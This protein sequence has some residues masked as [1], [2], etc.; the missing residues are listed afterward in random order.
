MNSPAGT[1]LR[2]NPHRLELARIGFEITAP[3]GTV[4]TLED[5]EA[6][7]QTLDLWNGII[8]SRF[9]AAGEEVR[10][11]T[12]CHP[13][14]D[15]LAFRFESP[16]IEA[17]RLKI[18]FRFPYGSKGFRIEPQDWDQPERHRTEIVRQS[19][20]RVDLKRVLDRDSYYVS[21]ASSPSGF[22][23]VGEHRYE[24]VPDKES[25]TF[26]FCAAFSPFEIN[27]DLP[28]FD[29]TGQAC[30]NHW[31]HFWEMGAAIDFSASTD[32]R[33]PEL[34]RR[35]V[36]SQY[37]TAVQCAGDTPPQETGLTCNSWHGKFHLEMHWWHGVHFALWGRL[38]LL[39]KSLGWYSE[40][41]SEARKIAR[42]QGYAGVR[43][44]KM[45]DPS[46][47]DSP[48][49]CGPYLIWQ[50]PHPIYYAELCYRE[51]GD[52]ATLAQYSKLVFETA[53]FMASYARWDEAGERYVLGPA[54]IPAQ[55]CY[56]PRDTM[57]PPFE[58]EYWSW[59]LATAGQWRERLGMEREPAWD[60]VLEKLSPPPMDE[61]AYQTAEGVWKNRDHP[62]LLGACGILPGRT[63]DREVMRRTL[64]MVMDEWDWQR[65][66]GWDFPMVA[67]TAARLDE[68]EL[69]IDVLMMDR[70]KNHYCP[71]GHNRQSTALPLYLPGNGGLL[72]AVA[73]MAA[74]WD[75][76]PDTHLP[77]FPNNGKWNVRW[78]NLR[79]MI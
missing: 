7:D 76:A 49:T 30:R 12:C 31:N 72:T 2:E 57:N 55:E 46:G 78:E 17:G 28:D 67:M 41:L 37:L 13:G 21:V 73:M 43:W 33:A 63:V 54:M 8:T 70:P 26:E 5:I 79:R 71:N 48:S 61:G 75:G 9:V 56:E 59:G 58:L 40:I 62:S 51:R 23:D 38:A 74:G 35:V 25:E 45:V 52:D 18:L 29:E 34:E 64:R 42:R 50:Q 60:R 53:E 4:I 1:W 36:L 39:E 65:V 24:L 19:K 16:L 15:M 66:W 27:S 68:P 32:A 22:T 47:I 77:G 20:A 44:P 14:M 10:A 3:D 6:I 69:A 11:Q